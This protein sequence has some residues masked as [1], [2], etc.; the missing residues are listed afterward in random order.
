M[1]ASTALPLPT[2]SNGRLPL[3]YLLL[4]A[5]LHLLLLLSLPQRPAMPLAAPDALQVRVQAFVQRPAPIPAIANTPATPATPATTGK[6]GHREPADT[7][8]STP[9]AAPDS[10]P[11]IT[12]SSMLSNARDQIRQ[13]ARQ[14]SAYQ[15]AQ[16][17]GFLETAG[18]EKASALGRALQ[19]T[20]AGEKR[21][22][23]GIVQI[24]NA[25]GSVYCL[26][27]T[28]DLRQRDTPVALLAV[29]STCP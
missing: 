9:A 29:P 3:P 18:D 21:L 14:R 15:Q 4:A 16:R 7:T 5:A 26:Q 28:S 1:T 22:A 17:H 12:S 6:P 19:K 24:T 20:D 11:L 23:N 13:E 8:D 27:A 25:D 2:A 10:A